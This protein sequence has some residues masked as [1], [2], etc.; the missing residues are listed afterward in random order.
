MLLFSTVLSINDKLTKEKFIKLAIKWNQGSR[1]RENVIPDIDWNGERN[2]RFGNDKVWMQI[3]EYRNQ[4][5]I[6]IR[7]EKIQNDGVVWDTDYV[8]NFNEMRM[9]IRLDRSYLEEAVTEYKTF[10]T[11]AFIS[12][13]IDGGYV[14]DD[15]GLPVAR[16]P[17][18]VD[19]DNLRL[20]ADV[21]NGNTHY[22]LPIVYISK[23]YDERNPVNEVE[24]AKRLKGVAHVFYQEHSWTVQTLQRLTNKN[25]EYDGA[26]GIYFPNQA[27]GHE[28]ILNHIY[29]GSRKK[30]ENRIVNR[31]IQ[32]SN[33]QRL[34]IL[35]TWQGVNNALLRDKY[36]SKR[37]ELKA[38]ESSRK[39]SAYLSNIAMHQAEL[40]SQY[41]DKRVEEMQKEV[42]EARELIESVDGELND[43]KNE[44]AELKNKVKELTRQN[45]SLNAL[46]DNLYASLHEVKGVPLLHFGSEDE[47]FPGEIKEFVLE[48]LDS[49][50]KTRIP[51]HTRRSDAIGDVIRSNG[52]VT[53]L[54]DKKKK[55]IKDVLGSYKSMTTPVRNCLK[56]IGLEIK[57]DDNHYKLVYYND[58]RYSTILAKTPSDQAHGGK[59]AAATIIKNML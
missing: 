5:I 38:Y 16:K 14:N 50:L 46:K 18:K 26:V 33:S 10:S 36:S 7:Y 54:P 57:D 58:R 6:A 48:I 53:K 42:E 13:L 8:M 3:E 34:D 43:L 51:A 37:E 25:N 59:N 39:L 17:I 9:A 41:A 35:L 23:T 12:L 30:M 49:E 29:P 1:H 40:K 45:D 28:K 56:D 32:Y 2:I 44:N 22:G 55:K 27:I 15:N 52:G 24:I 20:I 47:F 11:P 4:N 31:V 21:I 19:E